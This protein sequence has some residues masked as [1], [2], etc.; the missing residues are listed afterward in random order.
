[1]K[2]NIILLILAIIFITSFYSSLKNKARMSFSEFE[3]LTKQQKLE[4]IRN[5]SEDKRFVEIAENYYYA[6]SNL[7]LEDYE[8]L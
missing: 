6:T 4:Y 8:S 7:D 2:T 5:N 3:V 1:M